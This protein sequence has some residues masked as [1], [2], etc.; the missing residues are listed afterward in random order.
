[1]GE[2]LRWLRLGWGKE[3]PHRRGRRAAASSLGRKRRGG[4]RRARGRRRVDGPSSRLL[5]V[6]LRVERTRCR[7]AAEG[8]RWASMLRAMRRR[9]LAMVLAGAAFAGTACRQ[10]PPKVDGPQPIERPPETTNRGAA[11]VFIDAAAPVRI[12][13][14]TLA[15]IP[16]PSSS[17]PSL[18][19]RSSGSRTPVPGGAGSS[20][21]RSTLPSAASS[22][23]RARPR[24]CSRGRRGL[25][26]RAGE[27][28]RVSPA[29]NAHAAPSASVRTRAARGSPVGALGEG[30]STARSASAQGVES[31]HLVAIQPA[32]LRFSARP[33]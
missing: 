23:T 19:S 29:A 7:T 22:S 15:E 1:M 2:G 8:L 30:S 33:A 6:L 11:P 17:P 12:E 32:P 20:R 14:E 16:G 13:T 27:A 3:L 18:R 24:R 31:Q 25:G 28:A 5:P 26:G 21:R 10:S 9:A 4:W